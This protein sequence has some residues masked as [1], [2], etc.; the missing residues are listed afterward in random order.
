M[1]VRGLSLYIL[2]SI[3]LFIDVS[4][5]KIRRGEE[6]GGVWFILPF[7]FVFTFFMPELF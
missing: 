3:Q 6:D 2:L 5:L 4:Q 7:V 1:G